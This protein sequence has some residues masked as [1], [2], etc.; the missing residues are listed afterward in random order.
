MAVTV[1][2]ASW[3]D[4][5]PRA[6]AIDCCVSPLIPHPVPFVVLSPGPP[7]N[8]P[9]KIPSPLG[10][11]QNRREVGKLRGTL[12]AMPIDFFLLP[13]R[14]GAQIVGLESGARPCLRPPV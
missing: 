9:S 7:P 12:V 8:R 1:G 13:A 3:R 5:H 2:S 10:P 14:G 4:Q 11:L 6:T